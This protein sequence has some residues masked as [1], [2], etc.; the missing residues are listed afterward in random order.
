MKKTLSAAVLALCAIF[1]VPGL[2][3][4]D[5]K[6]NLVNALTRNDIQTGERLIHENAKSMSAEEKKLIVNFVLNYTR[7]ENTKK[8][9]EF[10][11]TNNIHVSQFD[12]YTALNRS[13]DGQV[14]QFILD[15]GIIPNGEILLLAA[16]KQRFDFAKKFVEMGA[17]VNYRYPQNKA[18]ADGMTVL[19][20][21][22]MWNNLE[23]VQFLVE[24]GAN[25]NWQ[26]K[27]GRSAASIAYENGQMPLYSYLKEQGADF[28]PNQVLVNPVPGANSSP[29][30]ANRGTGISDLLNSQAPV[31]RNGAYRLSGNTMEIRLTGAA[32]P[33][34]VSYT[35]NFGRASS[36]FFRADG[37]ILTLVME[38][39]SFVYR[40]VS[41]VSFFGN[42][43]T[44]VRTGD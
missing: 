15:Q 4:D 41:D 11:K 13:Q 31:L 36:G 18:Y 27:D 3:A 35:N 25:I 32:N 12:L 42:G 2:K 39:R 8:L 33:G 5:F 40:I 44:W 37:G 14:I 28:D 17:D 10:L 6:W 19:L 9:L 38:G 30:P 34:T 22:S 29:S 20:Y 7:G 23:L 1:L 43:E 26:A 16:E 24:H 21:A